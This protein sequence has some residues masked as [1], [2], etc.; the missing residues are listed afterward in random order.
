MN[1][2]LASFVTECRD[3][4]ETSSKALLDLENDTG[5]KEQIDL[6]FRAIHT[7]KGAAGLFEFSPL[8]ST[9]HAGEDLLDAVR[10][11]DVAF[12]TEIADVLLE[13][14]DRVTEWL[15]DIEASEQLRDGSDAIADGLSQRLRSL[16]QEGDIVVQS[17]DVSGDEEEALGGWPDGVEPFE[18]DADTLTFVEYRPSETAFFTGD[19]PLQTVLATP[20]LEWVEVVQPETWDDVADLDPFLLKIGFRIV[21]S[22]DAETLDGHFAYVAEEI[23]V[24]RFSPSVSA[25]AGAAPRV[26]LSEIASDLLA[27]QHTL[28]TT[29][30]EGQAE[31]NC[32]ASVK[33]VLTRVARQLGA[34]APTVD[35]TGDPDDQ[36]AALLASIEALQTALV[37]AEVEKVVVQ[38]DASAPARDV[39]AQ[40]TIATAQRNSS[41]LRVDSDRV[42]MLMNLAGELVVAKNAIPFL[43]QRAEGLDGARDLVR[44]IKSQHNT[45]NRIAEELQAAI[46][47][48]RM[49]PVGNILGRFN[50][51]VRDM[52]RKLGKDIQYLVE[53]E[54][55]EADKTIVDELSEPIVHLIRNSIDHGIEMPKD[56]VAIGKSETGTIHVRASHREESVVIEI[57]DDGNGINVERVMNKAIE[58]GLIDRDKAEAL[59]REEAL[60]LIFL[61]GLSTKEEVSDLSGRGVGMD[62]VASMV[63]RM[64][65]QISIASEAQ[66]GTTITVS[67]PLSMAVQRL[68]MVEVGQ[69][70]YGVPVDNVV[71]CQKIDATHISRHRG[72]EMLLI[73]DRL[74][75]LLRL[76]DLFNADTPTDEA[77]QSVMIVNVEGNETG[78]V[79]NRF[80]PGV[81]AIVKPMSGVMSRYNCYSGTA[82]LGDGSILLALNLPE[83]VSCQL[84]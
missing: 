74:V 83:I 23:T 12:S 58:R 49:V 17:A 24:E 29:P 6:L 18:T 38:E 5:N 8:T 10:S 32:L 69:G 28:L 64:G 79:V 9:V 82:L 27:S 30:K 45:I 60:Q 11:G 3:L 73:R 72:S 53:G 76:D 13:V 36:R 51:L 47:Q 40:A 81:D 1:Q 63:R 20:G 61:P 52:S 25:G 37:P 57:S 39:D 68:M 62:V 50:R 80:H 2:L 21:S 14:L 22:A 16:I 66:K 19:D 84:H 56:R 35:L 44:E 78:L 67:L 77:E 75:P 41:F 33:D 65:G 7:I 70:L 59:S 34:D 42:D 4:I 15:D 46:M 71:E 54:E 31:L 48:I 55:T 26:E 43:A